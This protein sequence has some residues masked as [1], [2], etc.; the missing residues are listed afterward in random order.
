LKIDK[1]IAIFPGSAGS[2]KNTITIEDPQSLQYVK[3]QKR[4]NIVHDSATIS[5]YI[6]SKDGRES[7]AGKLKVEVK[8]IPEDNDDK[9]KKV[10]IIRVKRSNEDSLFSFSPEDKRNLLDSINMYF[11]QGFV[12]FKE[13]TDYQDSLIVNFSTNDS[14][15][16][17]RLQFHNILPSSEQNAANVSYIFLCSQGINKQNG[18]AL[19]NSIV[20]FVRNPV[21]ATH[22]LGHRLGLRDIWTDRN[23]ISQ[24]S[25]KNIMDYPVQGERE[26]RKHFF[27]FQIK[28]IK[29]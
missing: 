8:K 25:T 3:I 29:K 5:A 27:Y 16:S 21:T 4:E 22:E 26:R 9:I 14:V 15:T 19:G 11:K 13:D 23:G 18:M 1:N 12:R 17:P 20:L 2:L 7:L 28:I 24:A 6:V 10:R